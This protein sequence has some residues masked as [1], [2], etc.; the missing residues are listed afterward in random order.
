M[1][2]K[3]A[4]PRGTHDA[5]PGQTPAWLW[6]ENVLRRVANRFSYRE[7]RF[8]TFEHTELFLRGV[9]DTTDVVQKEMYTFT[10]KGGRSIT[11]RPEGTASVVRAFVEHA[12]YA[13]PLPLKVYYIAP[14][15]RYEKPQAGR[16]REHHQFGVEC[17]GPA[18]PAADA[19]VIGLAHG[20]INALGLKGIALRVNS[21]GC[22]VC[23]PQYHQALG[24][25]F[26]AH[27]ETLCHTC[28]DRLARN[29]L[30]ILDC[31]NKPCA[32]LAADAPAM[33][34]DLCDLCRD[35]QAGLEAH[36]AAMGIAFTIDPM[37]VRGLDYYTRT[38]FEFVSDTIGAQGTVCGGGRYDSLVE[39]LGGPPTPALGF[40]SGIERLL[41]M[42]HAQG[43]IPGDTDRCQLYIATMG[44]RAEVYAAS[45]AAN[46][47][48]KG[49]CAERDLMGRSLKAQMKAA[50]RSGAAYSL[51][52]GDDEMETRRGI[53]KRMDGE[54]SDAPVA[55]EAE[56][57]LSALES[58][59]CCGIPLSD[60][61]A[62]FAE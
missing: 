33:T 48:A 54:G 11:L 17:F 55:L 14:N 27:R 40:G 15:F 9:G 20:Y 34:D 60:A 42:C 16:L 37:L 10:D 23:R 52:V 47:R 4:A 8:P 31:K 51:V 22:P 36:L 18:S 3:L 26:E 58:Q 30:R 1:A 24:T 6:L 61:P 32:A 19:E 46:L 41:M 53:L 2:E 44:G 21:I 59:G 29:P 56:E 38:V 49:I 25:F 57:I 12:L 62:C 45:L 7:I 13:G 35:H 39:T 28:H 5:L 50:N 43:L